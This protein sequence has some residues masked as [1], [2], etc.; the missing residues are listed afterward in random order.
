MTSWP[1]GQVAWIYYSSAVLAW[2]TERVPERV[3]LESVPV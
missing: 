2:M 1:K 3:V